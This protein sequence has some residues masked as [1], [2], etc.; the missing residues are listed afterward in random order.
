[1]ADPR[2]LLADAARRLASAG[3]DS[4]RV[5]AE[6]LLA[7]VLDV[8]RTRLVT[9][10]D[11]PDAAALIFAEHV[12]RRAAR[13]P[14]QH[15]TGT[16]PFRG[17]ELRVGPGVF[18]PR[19]ET[20]L[21]VDA[22]LPHL[23]AIESP[24]VVDLCSGSGALAL[25]IAAEV[26]GAKVVA[27]EYSA[28]A[29]SWLERNADGSAVRVVAADVRDAQLLRELHGRVDAVVSNPPYVPATTSV[30]PEVRADPRDAVF[31]GPDGLDLMPA[32]VARAAE[33][34]RAG[35]V[36]AVEHD[37]THGAAVPALIRAD[38]RFA[39]VVGHPDLSG[40]CRFVT[41]RRFSGHR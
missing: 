34:L 11:V 40:R 35:G 30:A 10:G 14:L 8:P 6:L 1:V 3:I 2:T 31:A 38:G 17:L 32:V 29:L 36:F 20:E 41:A 15:I 39:D 19:F 33:L 21:L 9:L 24:T 26:P 4:P 37:D 27:V 13:E 25:A 23:R 16:A 28:A 7:E 22:V 18:V 12:E 5:D